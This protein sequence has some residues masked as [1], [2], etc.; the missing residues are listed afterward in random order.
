M[1]AGSCAHMGL[2][3]LEWVLRGPT[4]TEEALYS[5]GAAHVR[6]NQ[7]TERKKKGLKKIKLPV[8]SHL[9]F[10]IER[11]GMLNVVQTEAPVQVLCPNI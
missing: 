3:H 4:Q 2:C 7:W 10:C 9:N 5:L 6:R 1:E 11:C 8:E